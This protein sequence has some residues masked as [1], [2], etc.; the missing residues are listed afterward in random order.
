[1]PVESTD[2]KSGYTFGRDEKLKSKILI[3][4]L[5]SKGKGISANPIRLVYFIGEQSEA[6]P[7]VLFSVSKRNFKKAVDRNHI[8]RQMR[9]IYRLNRDLYLSA[10]QNKVMLLAFIY[11]AKEKIP[12]KVL[13]KKLNLTLERLMKTVG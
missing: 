4:K 11:N 8:K 12:Y 6:L 1:M 5:F 13:E 3:D 9:E 7:K 2:K 10:S